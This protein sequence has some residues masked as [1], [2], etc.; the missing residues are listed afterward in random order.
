MNNEEAQPPKEPEVFGP[1][2]AAKILGIPRHV[3]ARLRRDGKIQGTRKGTTTIYTRAQLD[4][5][6]LDREKPGPKAG[7]GSR[8]GRAKYSWPGDDN[9]TS[10]AHRWRICDTDGSPEWK[11]RQAVGA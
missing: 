7:A 2:E 8:L 11:S 4:A 5:A 10:L 1:S 9:D 3:L 6:I